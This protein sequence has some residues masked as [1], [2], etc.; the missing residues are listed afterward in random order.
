[1]KIFLGGTCPS[2]IEDFNYRTLLIPF[3][4]KNN[5]DYFNPVVEDWTEDCIQ[6]EEQEKNICDVHLYVIAP[7]MKGVYSIAECFGSIIKNKKRS[8]L[9]FIDRIQDKP[10]EKNQLKSLVATGKLLSECGG[11]SFELDNESELYMLIDIL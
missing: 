6:I 3:L 4:E 9:V 11:E 7:N 1:M 10:F 2:S 8:I 5:I